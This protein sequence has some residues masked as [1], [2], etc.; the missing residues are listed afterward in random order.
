MYELSRVRLHAVGPPGAR[1]ADVTL[2]FSGVG[3]EVTGPRQ[4]ALFTPAPAAGSAPATTRSSASARSSTTASGSVPGGTKNGT[5]TGDTRAR[6]PSPA[7]V[8]FLENGGG[9]SVLIKLIF[10]VV[11][12]GRRQVVG[13]SN[14]RVLDN[15]VLPGDTGH[16]VCEWQHAGTGQRLLTGKVSEWRGR[17]TDAGRLTEAWYSLRPTGGTSG[18]AEAAEASGMGIDGLP[19]TEQG[20]QVTLSGFRTRLQDAHTAEPALALAWL[21]QQG[22]W[23]EQLD[24]LGLDPELF[25]YQR[26]MNAGEGEAAEAFSFGSD[27]QF[28]EFLLRAVTAAEDPDGLAD[29]VDGYAA[30]LAQ[31]AVLGAERDFV[32]GALERLAPLVTAVDQRTAAATAHAATTA[33]ATRLH[34]RLR[35][36][37]RRDEAARAGLDAQLEASRSAERDAHQ[38]RARAHGEVLALRRRVVELRVDE[39]VRERDRLAAAAADAGAEIDAW[40][41]VGDVLRLGAATA[42]AGRLTRLVTDAEGAAATVLADRDSAARALL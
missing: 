8:L 15:F 24:A 21:T 10:S 38:A 30:R 28:V 6:R 7:S 23:S 31:R 12:P 19:F 41:A 3:G 26:A 14:G 27:E 37:L 18:A 5:G 1:F 22:A 39:A 32:Q 40:R 9:K 35:A 25:R 4:D 17:G 34:D 33:R 13:T 20:R 36:R 11:L 2:D 16:V 42:E 29:V